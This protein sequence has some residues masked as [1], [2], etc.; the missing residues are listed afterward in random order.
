V[1]AHISPNPLLEPPINKESERPKPLL[2]YNHS[3]KKLL[4]Y[5]IRKIYTGHGEEVY[6]LPELVEKRLK[7]QHERAMTV[8]EFITA[9]PLSVFEICKLLFPTVYEKE[10]SL[11]ISETVGQMDYLMSLGEIDKIEKNK[12]IRYIAI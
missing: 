3:L 7:R 1:L 10:L 5:S 11:T 8:K 2:Q 6:N 12:I 9:E 4:N